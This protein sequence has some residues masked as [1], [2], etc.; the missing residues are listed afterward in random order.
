MTDELKAAIDAVVKAK[1]EM[2][3]EAGRLNVDSLMA[4][5]F[6]LAV[7]PEE[8]AEV[9]RYLTSRLAA[10]RRRRPD[11]PA[12]EILDNCIQAIN[13][14]YI[15]KRYFNKD[16]SWLSQRLNGSIVN[17]KPATFTE[18]EL[19]ILSESL[20]DIGSIISKSSLLIQSNL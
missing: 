8:K 14:S 11:V 12:K 1:S 19:R 20:S 4:K 7:T 5:A 18:D 9:G 13:L 15:A 16:R 6:A 2:K 17:G 10:S 3:T